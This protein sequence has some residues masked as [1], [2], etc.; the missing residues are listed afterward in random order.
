MNDRRRSDLASTLP[1][2]RP[3]NPGSLHG[4]V[5]GVLVDQVGTLN[6]ASWLGECL[7]MEG[8]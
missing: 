1:S 4:P 8:G 3:V 6:A 2:G 7:C 5:H